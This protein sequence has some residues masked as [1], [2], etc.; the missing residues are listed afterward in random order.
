MA[1][2][3]HFVTMYVWYKKIEKKSLIDW[4]SL[5]QYF[6]LKLENFH[7][8][9][10]SFALFWLSFTYNACILVKKYN[11]LKILILLCGHLD[12]EWAV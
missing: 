12:L 7:S 2:H 10:K 5:Y 3:R 4:Q 11:F 9:I 6:N 1:V 8:N